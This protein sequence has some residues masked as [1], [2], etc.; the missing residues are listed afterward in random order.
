MA[1]NDR[2]GNWAV[3]ASGRGGRAPALAIDSLSILSF[4]SFEHGTGPLP[5]EKVCGFRFPDLRRRTHLPAEATAVSLMKHQTE[6]CTMPQMNPIEGPETQMID[7]TKYDEDDAFRGSD[8]QDRFG[9]LLLAYN[10]AHH[11]LLEATGPSNVRRNAEADG[12]DIKII[13]CSTTSTLT[14]SVVGEDGETRLEP[15]DFRTT[16]RMPLFPD[17]SYDHDQPEAYVVRLMTCW[18]EAS[19]LGHHVAILEQIRALPMDRSAL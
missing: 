7:G 16:F 18:L 11:D 14:A 10:A 6:D 12:F 1:N 15:L 2:S 3:T 9:L 19:F 5:R 17:F 13:G 8:L 4:E